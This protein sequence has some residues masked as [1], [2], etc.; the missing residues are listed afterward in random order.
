MEH[1]NR[2][3]PRVSTPREEQQRQDASEELTESSTDEDDEYRERLERAKKLARSE[4]TVRQWDR[5]AGLYTRTHTHTHTHSEALIQKNCG[6][7]RRYKFCEID[8]DEALGPVLD[9]LE[10]ISCHRCA[11]A[12]CPAITCLRTCVCVC[13]C[14]CVPESVRACVCV[15]L[16]ACV[17]ACVL[18]CVRACVRALCVCVSERAMGEV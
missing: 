9:N 6:P 5:S 7:L 13:V 12:R 14:K 10:R 18:A 3:T 15:C 2:S 16:R 8:L 17:H 11:R 1:E 4:I